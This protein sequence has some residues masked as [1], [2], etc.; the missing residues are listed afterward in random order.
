MGVGVQ[1]IS[2]RLGEEGRWVGGFD[3][4]PGGGVV[5]CFSCDYAQ[6]LA[7][8]EFRS[9]HTLIDASQSDSSRAAKETSA[10]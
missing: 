2:Y 5:F 3:E 1:L 10:A 9:A 8:N 6:L 4:A 7:G